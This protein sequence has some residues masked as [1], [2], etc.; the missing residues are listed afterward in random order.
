M[1]VGDLVRRRALTWDLALISARGQIGESS[2]FDPLNGRIFKV[3]KSAAAAG[4]PMRTETLSLIQFLDQR[5][6]VVTYGVPSGGRETVGVPFTHVALLTSASSTSGVGLSFDLC[7]EI[8]EQIES[9]FDQSIDPSASVR[10]RSATTGILSGGEI[11]AYIGDGVFVPLENEQPTGRVRIGPSL[12]A[13]EE[14]VIFGDRVAGIY[15]GQSALAFGSGGLI[16]P[17]S[18]RLGLP[19]DIWFYLEAKAGMAGPNASTAV[20]DVNQRGTQ[21]VKLIE[22]TDEADVRFCFEFAH[23]DP[24]LGYTNTLYIEVTLDERP[25]RLLRNPPQGRPSFAV[26]GL[27]VTNEDLADGVDAFWF[28]LDGDG[29]PVGSAMTQR[30]TTIVRDGRRTRC[31]SWRRYE[32]EAQVAGFRVAAERGG[33]VFRRANDLPLCFLEAPSIPLP[34]IFQADWSAIFQADWWTTQGYHLDWLDFAGCVEN[35]LRNRGLAEI[36]AAR[37]NVIMPS[38]AT[39]SDREFEVGPLILRRT[40]R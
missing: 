12:D 1:A 3:Q 24:A 30:E 28:D 36:H 22:Q 16:T 35:A 7:R 31:Y 34:A 5:H 4:R 14:P 15:R 9:R 29:Y 38:F 19:E 39:A 37:G 40:E 10:V 13:L 18:A 32:Y 20:I 2:D 25:S 23:P 8:E 6:N 21:A 26:V 27:R 33:F 17:A 11:I